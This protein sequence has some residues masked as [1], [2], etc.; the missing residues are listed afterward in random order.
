V[1]DRQPSLFRDTAAGLS[2]AQQTVRFH[3]SDFDEKRDAPRLGKQLQAVYDV[4]SDGGWWTAEMVHKRL[5]VTHAAMGWLVQS[6]DRQM[7]YLKDIPGCSVEKRRRDP[8]RT[9]AGARVLPEEPRGNG[10]YVYRLVREE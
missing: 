2:V 4:M 9:N 3:G 8:L 1:P 5:S 7:R 10:H 6:I